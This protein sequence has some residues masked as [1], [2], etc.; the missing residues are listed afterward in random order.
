[1]IRPTLVVLAAALACPAAQAGP[2]TAAEPLGSCPSAVG[3]PHIVD[4]WTLVA[5]GDP[6]IRLAD[7]NGDGYACASAVRSPGGRV[8]LHLLTDNA[9]GDPHLVPPGPCTDPFRAVA[10]EDPDELPWLRELDANGDRL[11][12]ATASLGRLAPTLVVVDDPNEL[13][14]A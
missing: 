6:S 10:I 5:I 12:C 2:A 11:V 14:G 7:R 1:M 8:L 13:P 4:P 9:I 3:D